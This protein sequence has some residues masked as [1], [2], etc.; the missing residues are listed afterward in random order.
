MILIEEDRAW[1][2]S[3]DNGGNFLSH[4]SRRIIAVFTLDSGTL[5]LSRR[6]LS[7]ESARR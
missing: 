7:I 6:A 1:A 4:L 2:F 3:G 5:G